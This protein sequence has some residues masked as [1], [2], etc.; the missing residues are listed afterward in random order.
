MNSRLTQK[1]LPLIKTLALLFA[2]FWNILFFIGFVAVA[3]HIP[4][5]LS[6]D[7]S[8]A[9]MAGWIGMGVLPI[10][11]C[12]AMGR[13]GIS[14]A[15]QLFFGL[16]FPLVAI[17]MARLAWAR[18]GTLA[19]NLASLILLVGA[20]SFALSIVRPE[21]R[22]TRPLLMASLLASTLLVG[23][24][25]GLNTILYSPLLVVAMVYIPFKWGLYGLLAVCQLL[26]LC[27]APVSVIVLYSGAWRTHVR[28]SHGAAPVLATSLAT[29]AGLLILTAVA[30]IQAQPG[31]LDALENGRLSP[32][33]VRHQ[34]ARLQRG[35]VEIV[36]APYRYIGARGQMYQLKEAYQSMACETPCGEWAQAAQNFL[37][38]PF[39]Y[40]GPG[41][42]DERADARLIYQQVFDSDIEASHRETFRQALNST[43]SRRN[44]D[45]TLLDQGAQ[46]VRIRSQEV[47]IEALETQGAPVAEIELH[48]TFINLTDVRREVFYTL[49]LP[50][51]AVVTGLW[52]GPSEDKALAFKPRVSPR[53]AAQAVYKAQVRRSVDPALVEQVGPRQYR[54]R[55]FP[56][57]P[58]D[59]LGRFAERAGPPQHL[60]LRYRT[61]AVDGQWPLPRLLEVRNAFWDGWTPLTINGKRSSRPSERSLFGKAMVPSWLPRGVASTG[62]HTGDAWSLVV[63]GHRVTVRPRENAR[64]NA[65]P[66]SVRALVAL[67]TSYSMEAVRG[68][69]GPALRELQVALPE[70]A[71]LV[72]VAS[73]YLKGDG[74][75]PLAIPPVWSEVQPIFHGGLSLVEVWRAAWPE[76]QKMGAEAV[77]VLTDDGDAAHRPAP[78]AAPPEIPLWFVHLGGKP[79]TA[80]DDSFLSALAQTGGGI[81]LSTEEV[82][83]RMA[84]PELRQA[85][86]YWVSIASDHAVDGEEGPSLRDE[87]TASDE[88]HPMFPLAAKWLIEEKAP[89]SNDAG[90]NRWHHL[91]QRAGIV[92]PYSSMIVLVN[93]RQ[94]QQLDEAEK[95]RDRFD[96]E[97][98]SGQTNARVGGGDFA[99]SDL[100]ATPEPGT[101]ALLGMGGLAAAWARRRR[102]VP[103]RSSSS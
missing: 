97:V 32:Q 56:V 31:V 18:D 1:L 4:E 39:L 27:L 17:A 26:A 65:G 52:L 41:T 34:E 6:N 13:W 83:R 9:F 98:E 81:A 66:V 33:E 43:W 99:S 48:E 14:T 44:A 25:V 28:G 88:T 91:A 5:V 12:V 59:G 86:A 15:V 73:P 47:T 29:L 96:R 50:E 42:T 30:S 37:L 84:H 36:L 64:T 78:L 68:A 90:L 92:T 20:A 87:A 102:T 101:W 49:E 55:V 58:H 95:R 61:L 82:L 3:E 75:P 57:E 45:A 76:A 100:V 80:Y 24:Y 85:D 67:D 63:D 2:V 89:G 51:A 22:K 71:R 7:G 74:H 38:Y 60:W 77:V 94:H 72:G 70:Q 46:T 16:Q 11:F 23:I 21:L 40:D 8:T 93:E 35:L 54:V 19:T 10:L 62:N 69:V 103:R 53:G 79:A